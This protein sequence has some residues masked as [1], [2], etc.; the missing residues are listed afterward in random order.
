MAPPKG[1]I[2]TS[3]YKEYVTRERAPDPSQA[4]LLVIDMQEHFRFCAED[5]LPAVLQIIQDARRAKVPIVYTR[6]A[7]KEGEDHGILGEWWDG[8]IDDA[9]KESELMPEVEF[10]PEQDKL[11][12]K[13]TYS[14]FH[15]TDLESYCKDL[16]RNEVIITGVMT[17][18]CCETTARDAFCRGFRVFF[19]TD[20]TS[21]SS[22]EMHTAT[23]LNIGF[24]F[25]YLVDKDSIKLDRELKSG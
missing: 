25:G 15:G 4:V 2:R 24:G 17:N 20:A 3:S 12:R 11:I 22:E 18:L 14:A 5:I 8:V 23:L 16:G 10:D 7:Y 9:L 6:T 21:T 19:S 1:F 13:L